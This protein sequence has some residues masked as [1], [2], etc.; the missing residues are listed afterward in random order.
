MFITPGALDVVLRLVASF[1]GEPATP[2]MAE[3][4]FVRF[5]VSADMVVVGGNVERGLSLAVGRKCEQL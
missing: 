3:S 4:T 1:G 2:P 5:D